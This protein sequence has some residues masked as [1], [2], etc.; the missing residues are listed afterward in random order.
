MSD[1]WIAEMKSIQ[2]DADSH[3]PQGPE[4]VLTIILSV[5]I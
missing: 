3:N 4:F 1:W 2:C 5:D